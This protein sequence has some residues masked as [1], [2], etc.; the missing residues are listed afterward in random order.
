M[1]PAMTARE[2]IAAGAPMIERP[3]LVG[4]RREAGRATS[5]AAER[6]GSGWDPGGTIAVAPGRVRTRSAATATGVVDAPI[7]TVA[8]S[9]APGSAASG[10]SGGRG[11][12]GTTAG[13]P[14]RPVTAAAGSATRG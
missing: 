4:A 7:A 2:K 9:A 6:A 5:A 13:R 12:A 11:A 3:A 8:G 14:G 1:V 10:P